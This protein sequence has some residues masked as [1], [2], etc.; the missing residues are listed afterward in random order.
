MT[1]ARVS[2]K[3]ALPSSWCCCFVD[4]HYSLSVA[5]ELA[6]CHIR[7]QSGFKPKVYE[8]SVPWCGAMAKKQPKA[9][10]SP[11]KK[12]ESLKAKRKSSLHKPGATP[13]STINE[14]VANSFRESQMASNAY[15]LQQL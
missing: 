5:T 11:A 3:H 12:E 1:Y 7:R 9:T 6:S 2:G 14:H 10:E 13:A 15:G 8:A 4:S